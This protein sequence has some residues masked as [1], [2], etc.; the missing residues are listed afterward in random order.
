[1]PAVQDGCTQ[2]D[3]FL[4]STNKKAGFS[5]LHAPEMSL[6]CPE[7]PNVT[8]GWPCCGRLTLGQHLH[9]RYT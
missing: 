1:M 4:P 6:A 2:E 7:T 5:Y 8:A 3:A 9:I